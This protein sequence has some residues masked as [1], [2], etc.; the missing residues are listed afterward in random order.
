M[1]GEKYYRE[2]PRWKG[3]LY[4]N[5]TLHRKIMIYGAIAGALLYLILAILNGYYRGLLWATLS[6]ALA[7]GSIL[8]ILRALKDL[9]VFW[10]KITIGDN[11]FLRN[12]RKS[13][14]Y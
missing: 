13:T 6:M 2:P 14:Q 4:A 1:T 3:G 9:F 10:W 7:G 11:E 8:A 5:F 12:M